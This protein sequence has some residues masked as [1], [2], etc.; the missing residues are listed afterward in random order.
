MAKEGN[1]TINIDGG[2]GD[3][4]DEYQDDLGIDTRKEAANR[5]T[6]LGLE[7][8]GYIGPME[9]QTTVMRA[10]RMATFT[11]FVIGTLWS[12]TGAYFELPA[13]MKMGLGSLVASAFVFAGYGALERREPAISRWFSRKFDPRSDLDA[14][15]DGGEEE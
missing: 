1:T 5:I 4:I 3:R 9:A 10:A 14:V 13:I 8:A 7:K 6:R 11:F 2:L 12:G 15:P